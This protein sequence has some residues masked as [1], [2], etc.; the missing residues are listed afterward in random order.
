[1][2]VVVVVGGGEGCPQL[3]LQLGDQAPLPP[4]RRLLLHLE[5]HGAGL[6]QAAPT[7]LRVPR[8]HLPRLG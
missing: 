3:E 1:M 5:A 4:G 2:V 8:H 7:G 6:R